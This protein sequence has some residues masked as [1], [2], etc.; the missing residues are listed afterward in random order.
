M[1]KQKSKRMSRRDFLRVSAVST[2][3]ILAAACAQPAPVAQEVEEEAPEMPEAMEFTL[4]SLD[5]VGWNEANTEL[6]KAFEEKTGHKGNLWGAGWPMNDTL[7]PA[8][9][10]GAPPDVYHDMPL[11]QAELYANGTAMTLNDL[12]DGSP[13]DPEDLSPVDMQACT[14]FG[15]IKQ[16]PLW[17][18]LTGHSFYV[19]RM[20]YFDE[21]GIPHPARHGGLA[22]YDQLY[23][24]A[25]KLTQRDASGNVSRWGWYRALSF[26]ILSRVLDD[27]EH[28]WDEENQEFTLTNDTVIKWINKLYFEPLE[29]GISPNEEQTPEMSDVEMMTEGVVAMTDRF[30]T[31]HIAEDAGRSE[32]EVMNHMQSPPAFEG[33]PDADRH[34]SGWGGWSCGIPSSIAGDRLQGA[35][36]LAT[37]QY[38]SDVARAFHRFVGP[39]GALKSYADDP[40]LDELYEETVYGGVTVDMYRWQVA[41]T[42]VF[43]GWEW[44]NL[45][46]PNWPGS[47]CGGGAYVGDSEE[48]AAARCERG[49]W[50]SG[51]YTAEELAEEWQ[52]WAT[53][54]R[55]EWYESIGVEV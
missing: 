21:A 29:L 51:K 47:R 23:D 33:Q 19:Y 14:W 31:L 32:A 43:F 22:S 11:K 38:N 46:M 13:W 12:V 4:L 40:Y 15:E 26:S 48:A 55:K 42:G 35:F 2:A 20:D 27:G 9:A 37:A 7:L 36:D 53:R 5:G 1:H 24:V 41:H 25:Q 8:I 16:M 28:W 34:F 3:G 52:E 10:A 49:S 6:I 50:V 17:H 18:D 45:S 44:G 39:P 30:F 54:V